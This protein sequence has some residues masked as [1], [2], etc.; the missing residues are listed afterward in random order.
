M[1]TTIREGDGS[2][3]GFEARALCRVSISTYSD[4]LSKAGHP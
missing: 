2:W 1:D 4:L 3:D